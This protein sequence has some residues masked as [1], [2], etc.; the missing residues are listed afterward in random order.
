MK[1]YRNIEELGAIARPV[2]TL[3]TFDGVHIGHRKL[4]E[5]VVEIA[6]K[7]KGESLVVTFDPHPDILFDCEG[8]TFRLLNSLNEKISLIEKSD[9]NHLLILPFNEQLSVLTAEDFIR[10][11]LLEKI[12]P[13]HIVVGYEYAFGKNRCGDFID[14]RNFAI[15]KKFKLT[16]ISPQKT[17]KIAISSEKIKLLLQNGNLKEA[18][19]LLGY[20]FFISGRVIRGNQIGKLIGYPTANIQIDDP[21]KL[22]P[23]FGV[24]ACRVQWKNNVYNGMANI[25]IRPTVNGK[26][27]T[28]EAHIFDFNEEIYENDICISLYHKMR[29]EKKF[30]GLEQ[31][32]EQL[33]NDK[34]NISKYFI[35]IT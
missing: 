3:G 10:N 2:V 14:L 35:D 7:E 28:V 13:V 31:L 25:G 9:I 32:K 18:N 1:I 22:I 33:R 11:I 5:K 34:I 30:G 17:Q 23:A 8:E 27:C 16:E 24:Y 12:K 4:L 19:E 15:E 29:D 6:Q 20:P 26:R 21:K